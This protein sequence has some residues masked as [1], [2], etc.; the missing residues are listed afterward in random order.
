MKRLVDNQ[1]FGAAPSQRSSLTPSLGMWIDMYGM[2]SQR[3]AIQISKTLLQPNPRSAPTDGALVTTSARNSGV[4]RTKNQS[5]SGRGQMFLSQTSRSMPTPRVLFFDTTSSRP[6]RGP[7]LKKKGAQ[8]RVVDCRR[9][10]V[11][12][13]KTA[14]RSRP[15]QRSDARRG[16]V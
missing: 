10:R 11:T 16:P 14:H 12:L 13:S 15:S 3:L 7:L 1:F 9:R 6:V 8:Q 5:R 2:A 4:S